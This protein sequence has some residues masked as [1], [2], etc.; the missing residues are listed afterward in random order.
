MCINEG[1]LGLVMRKLQ[2]EK[3]QLAGL[4]MN[5]ARLVLFLMHAE[6]EIIT[7]IVA[8]KPSRKKAA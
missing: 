3:R 4:T 1:R 7:P 5:E 8:N 6:N 2:S